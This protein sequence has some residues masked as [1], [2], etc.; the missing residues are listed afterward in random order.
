MED[1]TGRPIP[2]PPTGRS[3]LLGYTDV[4]YHRQRLHT[5]LEYANAA[6]YENKHQAS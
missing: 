6:A 2:T 1:G 3:A 4:F 5:A